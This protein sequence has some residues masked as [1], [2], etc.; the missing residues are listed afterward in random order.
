MI[1]RLLLIGSAAMALSAQPGTP[2]RPGRG[3]GG[4]RFLGAEAGMPARVVKNA[5]YSAEMV[6]ETTQVLADGNRIHQVITAHVYRDSD[7]RT[8]TEEPLNGLGALA[9]NSR[10]PTVVFIHDP[11]AGA[12]YALNPANKTA[13]RSA[14]MPRGRGGQGRGMRDFPGRG[15]SANSKTENLPRQTIEGLPA[16]GTRV[17]MTIPAGQVGNERPIQTVTER[18]YSPDLQTVLLLKQSDPRVGETVMRLVNVSRA[19]PAH[20]LF[21]VPADYKIGEPGSRSHSGAR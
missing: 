9:P 16:D 13:T 10:F 12:N 18:W 5:P 6:T 21:E 19:E 11:V 7:G 17:T 3:F 8:R 2:P 20:A 15:Q 4:M 1:C 14:W